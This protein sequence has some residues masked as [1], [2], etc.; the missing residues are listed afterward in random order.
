M[1]QFPGPGQKSFAPGAMPPAPSNLSSCYSGQSICNPSKLVKVTKLG[2][3][4]G[5][6][7]LL[8]RIPASG[9]GYL[10][11]SDDDTN[12]YGSG[13]DTVMALYKNKC[14]PKDE[15]IMQV[16]TLLNGLVAKVNNLLDKLPPKPP[17][18]LKSM[19]PIIAQHLV[20]SGQ[21]QLA[22]PKDNF[23]PWDQ[24]KDD[25]CPMDPIKCPVERVAALAYVQVTFAECLGC[26]TKKDLLP[27]SPPDDVKLPMGQSF[28]VKWSELYNSEFN[29]TTCDIVT[30]KVM[31]T[32]PTMFLEECYKDL[33]KMVDLEVEGMSSDEEDPQTP[34]LYRVKHI[35]QLLLSIIQF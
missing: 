20:A 3:V 35:K 26:R 22:A 27:P 21:R 23:S 6:V 32:F 29:T 11:N 5:Q 7:S 33:F 18:T 8:T 19:H 31:E 1:S 12:D 2:K 25:D 4:R 24:T 15:T 16:M 9:G 10:S 14:A 28:W 30:Q 13:T 34:G 17:S